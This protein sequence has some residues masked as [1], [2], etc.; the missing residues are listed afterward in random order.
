MPP[1]YPIFILGCFLSA[2]FCEKSFSFS[3]LYLFVKL[4]LFSI[5]YLHKK[6]L[7]SMLVT[8][9]ILTFFKFTQFSNVANCIVLTFLGTL[10]VLNYNFSE[11][12]FQYSL[13][14]LEDCIFFHHCIPTDASS[15]YCASLK[16]LTCSSTCHKLPEAPFSNFSK[17]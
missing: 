17:L 5:F 13:M 15:L 14:I 7:L 10:T 6:A 12:S 1:S 9:F 4:L 8:D 2:T 16:D 11:L 3:D